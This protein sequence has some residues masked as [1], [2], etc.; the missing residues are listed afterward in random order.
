MFFFRLIRDNLRDQ[1]FA[2]SAVISAS[3]VVMKTI[4]IF[5]S[6]LFFTNFAFCSFRND[7]NTGNKL[8]YKKNYE[9][10]VEK[11]N[12]AELQKP[13]SAIVY[14]NRGNSF[15]KQQL[16]DQAVKEYQKALGLTKDKNLKS[17]ILF[18]LGNTY[19]KLGDTKN[20]KESYK[21]GLLNNS[22]DED[23]KYNLQYALMQLQQNQK[24]QNQQ[25]KSSS[26]KQNQSE[27]KNKQQKEEQKKY[28]SE[29]DLQRLLEMAK[30]QQN[31]NQKD[32][33]DALKPQKPQLPSVDKD[34]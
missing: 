30:Q 23:I 18:N 13:D 5:L 6:T 17:K 16:Y 9:Q 11:Y 25:Q 2:S 26:N 3:S 12:S 32:L 24:N 31:K 20:A 27:D 22:N 7:I 34:W 8:F 4:I 19:L 21:Q 29:Q 15:Y 33:K 1:R 28:M 10:S 14:Y